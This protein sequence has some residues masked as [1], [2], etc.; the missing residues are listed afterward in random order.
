M[1]LILMTWRQ[2]AGSKRILSSCIGLRQNFILT[3]VAWLLF[4]GAMLCLIFLLL[5]LLAMPA[6]A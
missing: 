1:L 5:P 4:H 3:V 2:R 6:M